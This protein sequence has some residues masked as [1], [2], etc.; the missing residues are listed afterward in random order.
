MTSAQAAIFRETLIHVARLRILDD[1]SQWQCFDCHEPL[2]P[3]QYVFQPTERN[4]V[5]V[6]N[7][8][9]LLQRVP[10]ALHCLACNLLPP[11]RN[12]SV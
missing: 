3:G 6:V 11:M 7:G 8:T 4:S 1:P 2:K 9:T 5:C 12:F 10:E